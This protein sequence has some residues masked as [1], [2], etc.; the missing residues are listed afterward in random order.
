MNTFLE[1]STK[2]ILNPNLP[3]LIS[4]KFAFKNQVEMSSQLEQNSEKNI[5]A[6]VNIWKNNFSYCL[7]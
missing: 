1:I 7:K 5:T 2:Q 6:Q 3:W 4:W